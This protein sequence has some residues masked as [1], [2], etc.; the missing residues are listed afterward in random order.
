[1]PSLSFK[2]SFRVSKCKVVLKNA[3]EFAAEGTEMVEFHSATGE[4][5]KHL[6]MDQEDFD[7]VVE[8]L[9]SSMFNLPFTANL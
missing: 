9:V 6:S 8:P 4:V 7:W 5:V 2:F 1:M 3:R